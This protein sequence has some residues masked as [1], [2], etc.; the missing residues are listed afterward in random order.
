MKRI[1]SSNIIFNH[2]NSFNENKN[3]CYLDLVVSSGYKYVSDTSKFFH[4]PIP[5]PG[6]VL[7]TGT[8]GNTHWSILC[9]CAH[10]VPSYLRGV[11]HIRIMFV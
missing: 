9:L 2:C 3:L 6:N 5:M 1:N 11:M 8:P 4:I 7:D 10:A